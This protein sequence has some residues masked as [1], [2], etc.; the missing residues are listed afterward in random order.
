MTDTARDRLPDVHSRYGAPMGRVGEKGDPDWPY[1][2]HLARV[3]LN[4][5]GYDRGGAYWGFDAP[6]YQ[7]W[8]ESGDDGVADVE[9]FLRAYDR[10]DAKAKVLANYPNARFYR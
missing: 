8:A 5:G 7:A 9:M 2:F 6:L 10:E 3:Y 1:R 4:S